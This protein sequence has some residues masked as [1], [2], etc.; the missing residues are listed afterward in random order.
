[1]QFCT[2]LWIKGEKMTISHHF[3]ESSLTHKSLVI[4]QPRP[5]KK[6]VRYNNSGF[7]SSIRPLLPLSFQADTHHKVGS[8]FKIGSVASK[9]SKKSSENSRSSSTMM[10]WR[11]NNKKLLRHLRSRKKSAEVLDLNKYIFSLAY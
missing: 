3:V 2:L 5:P 1:M 6:S 11:Q 4:I 9:Y 10:I 7:A 8:D